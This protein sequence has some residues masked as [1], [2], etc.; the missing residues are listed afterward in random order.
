MIS[1]ETWQ[2]E[3]VRTSTGRSRS[4]LKANVKTTMSKG[5]RIHVG[6]NIVI[7]HLNQPS[8]FAPSLSHSLFLL[9]YRSL[10]PTLAF[11]CQ[12]V[13]L[14]NLVSND[15]ASSITFASVSSGSVQ[16][17]EEAYCQT[18]IPIRPRTPS[19][20]SRRSIPSASKITICRSSRA[21]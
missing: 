9:L 18:P 21:C 7:R 3:S 15:T 11:P 10:P 13:N 4:I 17:F 8:S 19:P 14:S 2:D 5:K 20:H 12:P 1:G 6:S 16:L